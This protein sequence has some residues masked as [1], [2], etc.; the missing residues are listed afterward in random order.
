MISTQVPAEGPATFETV[1]AALQE[2][3]RMIKENSRE[4]DRRREEI[5]RRFKA[6]DRQMK[7]TDKRVGEISNRFG[8]MVEHMVVPN[9]VARFSELGYVFEDTSPNKELSD[10]AH[11]IS[12]EVDAYLENKDCVMA[13]ETKVKPSEKDVDD[14]INRLEKLRAIANYRNETKKYYGAIAGVV[15]SKEVKAYIL[16]HGFFA[17]EPS[18]ETFRITPPPEPND[19]TGNA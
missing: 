7:A 16:S 4:A 17:I 5:D 2:T 13:V 14:H 19:G 6:T 18:G 10:R 11:G 8:D 9:L 12:C 1:W 15:M 3:D